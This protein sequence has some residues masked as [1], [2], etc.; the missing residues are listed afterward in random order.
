[1]NEVTITQNLVREFWVDSRVFDLPIRIFE[2]RNEKANGN[3]LEVL[4]E[5]NLGYVM[6]PIQVKIIK[7]NE[8]HAQC[9]LLK[10][11]HF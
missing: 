4:I 9:L 8:E 3:D 6:L 2:S 10:I 5:T 7:E 1:M 11:K